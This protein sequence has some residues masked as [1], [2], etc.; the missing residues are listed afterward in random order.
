MA[1]IPENVRWPI[2]LGYKRPGVYIQEWVTNRAAAPETTE[3]V[4]HVIGKGSKYF[5]VRGEEVIRAYVYGEL[6]GLESGEEITFDNP[7]VSMKDKTSVYYPDGTEV[8]ENKWDFFSKEGKIVGVK[9]NSS[10]IDANNEYSEEWAVDYQSSRRALADP[11]SFAPVK[12]SA[13]G[14]YQGEQRF[15]EDVDF[16]FHGSM[17]PDYSGAGSQDAVVSAVKVLHATWKNVAIAEESVA[18]SLYDK[19]NYSSD[20]I[21]ILKHELEAG[22]TDAGIGSTLEIAVGDLPASLPTVNKVYCLRIQKIDASNARIYSYE[23]TPEGNTYADSDYDITG[24]VDNYQD[25]VIAA[26]NVIT[27]N[28]G[29]EVTFTNIG[30]LAATEVQFAFISIKHPVRIEDFNESLENTNNAYMVALLTHQ[31][32]KTLTG[33]LE[34]EAVAASKTIQSVAYTAKT[35]GIGGNSLAIHLDELAG[36]NLL[37]VTVIGSVVYVQLA[38]TAGSSTSTALDV[39]N[40]I[41]ADSPGAN[42]LV[43]MVIADGEDGTI[44]TTSG[45]INLEGGSDDESYTVPANIASVEILKE[46]PF[47]IPGNVRVRSFATEQTTLEIIYYEIIFESEARTLVYKGELVKSEGIYPPLNIFGLS[48]TYGDA[49]ELAPADNDVVFG[50]DTFFLRAP[51]TF[52]N[53]GR[54]DITLDAVL[55]N[56]EDHTIYKTRFSVDVTYLEGI[57]NAKNTPLSMELDNQVPNSVPANLDEEV[58]Y[59][60]GRISRGDLGGLVVRNL[61]SFVAGQEIVVDVQTDQYIDWSKTDVTT[62]SFSNDSVLIDKNGL[63]TGVANKKYVILSENAFLDT[64]RLLDPTTGERKSSSYWSIPTILA[65]GAEYHNVIVI[66]DEGTVEDFKVRYNYVGNEPNPSQAYFVDALITR[67]PSHY[68]KPHLLSLDISQGKDK[69]E[70]ELFLGPMDDKHNDVLI[71]S[72][73]ATDNGN[74]KIVV[75]IVKDMDGDGV[76]QNTDYDAAVT[77]AKV[78]PHA[79]DLV[80]L[81]GAYNVGAYLEMARYRNHPDQKLWSMYYIGP[82]G[83]LPIGDENTP[84]SVIGLAVGPLN[85]PTEDNIAGNFLATAHREA[86]VDVV[87]DNGSVIERVVNGSFVMAAVCSLIT[88]FESP[89]RESILR[90]NLT[91]FKWIDEVDVELAG[92]YNLV[93]LEDQGNGVYQIGEDYTTSKLE[94]FKDSPDQILKQIV[95]KAVRAS[96]KGLIGLTYASKALAAE[97]VGSAIKTTLM[98]LVG[99][100]VIPPYQEVNE[101]GFGTGEERDLGPE[102]VIAAYDE[103]VKGNFYFQY[104]FFGF[105]RN[106]RMFGVYTFLT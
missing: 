91:N 102:D 98:S 73:M 63:I 54:K 35:P 81:N 16:F 33:A 6:H 7:L 69:T 99:Q 40:A 2:G 22:D 92:T 51:K 21:L 17:T 66:D 1:E 104:Q 83:E 8:P 90:K 85:N 36:D 88:S 70:A 45:E 82:Q 106:K 23:R 105:N 86:G 19:L 78:Y 75:T 71:A 14:L 101:E 43:S 52:K 57:E 97:D 32:N 100:I 49:Q 44:Q 59:D 76:Y 27:I 9:I 94:V 84:N 55:N 20:D 30:D 29:L 39:K 38:T 11:V 24:L 77:A 50:H 60:V 12:V 28:N 37:D 53:Y 25:V 5:K 67:D 56:S 95:E 10:V 3:R 18:W 48:I 46:Q 65:E 74:N 103:R 72:R 4:T 34:D 47:P 89:G 41:T 62:D 26:N 42:D 58:V 64:I 15:E 13:V 80:I 79:S 93:Y 87:L 96:A 68:N 31:T 61:G